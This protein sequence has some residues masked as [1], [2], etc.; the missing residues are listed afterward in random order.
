[1]PVYIKDVK[2]LDALPSSP[3]NL[4]DFK[5]E[6]VNYEDKREVIKNLWINFDPK[7]WSL[8]KVTYIRYEGTPKSYLGEGRV[9]YITEGT[10]HG[11]MRN[12]D[13][14][15]KYSFASMGVYGEEGNYDIK[16]MWL[17]R[18]TDIP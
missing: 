18:G 8:W 11:I 13:H 4:D 6:I 3:W 12:L 7:S 16:S 10:M 17:W 5:R 9:S 2:P 14:F 1:M 15:R